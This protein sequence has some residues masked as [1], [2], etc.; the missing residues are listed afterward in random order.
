MADVES[1]NLLTA[2][3]MLGLQL[4]VLYASAERDFEVV[5]ARVREL[6]AG[7]LVIG[8]DLF[9]N[10]RLPQLAALTDRYRVPAIHQFREFAAA[11]GLMS[12]GGDV[13]DT[14]RTLGHYAGGILKGG[15]AAD[16]PIQQATKV[17]MV[18]NLKAAAALGV[19]FPL[20]LLSRADEVIE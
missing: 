10:S 11:G 14:Y 2:A 6:G 15:S 13:A 7:A 9:F 5:F 1:R 3:G 19:T 8:N 17:Q 20:A 4:R 18:I 16:L 12:Y